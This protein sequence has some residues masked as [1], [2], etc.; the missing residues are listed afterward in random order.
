V[1]EWIDTFMLLW[2]N[3]FS[4]Q[5]MG[6]GSLLEFR[7]DSKEACRTKIDR[8]KDQKKAMSCLDIAL[9]GFL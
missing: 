5:H 8:A 4:W 9:I 6:I 2:M 1:G 3:F 7:V